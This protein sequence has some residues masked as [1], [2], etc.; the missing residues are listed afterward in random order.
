ML[1]ELLA[2]YDH[3]HEWF[4][5]AP[6]LEADIRALPSV[7]GGRNWGGGGRNG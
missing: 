5:L 2:K 4:G 6:D 3:C 7:H 1:S